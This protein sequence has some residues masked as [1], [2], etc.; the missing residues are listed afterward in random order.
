MYNYSDMFLLLS[1]LHG[2][3]MYH[4]RFVCVFVAFCCCDHE[5]TRPTDHCT[6][7]QLRQDGVHWSQ[8]V[9]SLCLFLTCILLVNEQ[10]LFALCKIV[11]S[12]E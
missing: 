7:V 3:Y 8:E 6:R 9:S 2:S 4:D 5:D 10:L 1:L 11:F 12:S